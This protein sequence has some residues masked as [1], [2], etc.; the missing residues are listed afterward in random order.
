MSLG[1]PTNRSLLFLRIF[2]IQKAALDIFCLTGRVQDLTSLK[3][4]QPSKAP[5]NRPFDAPKG[6]A[7]LPTIHFQV[8][9]VSFREFIGLLVGVLNGFQVSTLS[10][11][12]FNS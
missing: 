4:S 6:K 3:R 9:T 10:T 5:E 7:C 8:Q 1:Q 2:H 12:I 11:K